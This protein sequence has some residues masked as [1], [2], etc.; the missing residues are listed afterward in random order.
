MSNLCLSGGAIGAD[1]RWGQ[2]AL[3]AGHEVIHFSFDGHKSTDKKNTF[4]LSEDELE[5]SD[6]FL[7]IAAKTLNRN[8]PPK[9]EFVKKLLQRNFYQ[10]RD[11]KTLYA[12]A[13]IKNGLVEGGTGW[14]V[15][16]FLDRAIGDC[17]VYDQKE[18]IW[19]QWKAGWVQNIPYKPKGIWTGIGTRYIN[20]FGISAIN[21]LLEV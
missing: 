13:S 14:A 18:K 17:F 4:I 20:K 21:E 8:F 3:L 7:R 15:Q 5:V 6:R 2:A 16:M 10:I 9:D 19:Y 12:V 1:T 11:S